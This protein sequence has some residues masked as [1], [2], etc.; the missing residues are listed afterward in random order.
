MCAHAEVASAIDNYFIVVMF[1]FYLTCLV[2]I[3]NTRLDDPWYR[4]LLESSLAISR[5]HIGMHAD[6]GYYS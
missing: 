3:F 6:V 5:M 2:L 4:H 1:P